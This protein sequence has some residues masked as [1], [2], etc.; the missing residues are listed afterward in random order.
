MPLSKKKLKAGH[1]KE[2]LWKAGFVY[3]KRTLKCD[4]P[5]CPF[6]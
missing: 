2:F 5:L 1:S 3:P 6:A 4:V